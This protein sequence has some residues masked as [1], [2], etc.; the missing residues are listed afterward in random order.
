MNWLPLKGN[1]NNG[2]YKTHENDV[3]CNNKI[4]YISGYNAFGLNFR[5]WTLDSGHTTINIVHIRTSPKHTHTTY[6]QNKTQRREE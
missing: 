6:Y 4:G 5:H 2:Q 3:T 1:M